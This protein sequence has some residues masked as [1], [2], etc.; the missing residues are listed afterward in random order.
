VAVTGRAD[1]DVL[2]GFAAGEEP[3]FAEIYQRYGGPMFAIALAIVGRRDLAADVVQQ[4]F[5]QAWRA[6]ASYSPDAAIAPWLFTITRRAAIDLWR[7]ERRHFLTREEHRVVDEVVPGPSLESVWEAWQVRQALEELPGDE[8][9]V[10]HLA[11]VEGLT[12]RET[13]DRLAIP[14]GPVQSRS[15]R[16]HQRLGRLL[17]HLVDE[18]PTEAGR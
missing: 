15:S 12:Q 5:V 1:Q 17:A 2:R 10:V 3:A 7:R 6:A 11:Y 13:A 9:D 18:Q 16:A 4:A 14:L 8:R